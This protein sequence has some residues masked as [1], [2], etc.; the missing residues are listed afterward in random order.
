MT[1]GEPPG[2]RRAYRLPR[3]LVL[4]LTLIAFGLT[5]TALGAWLL[6]FLGWI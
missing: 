1:S 6:I 2:Q 4:V 3:L 5:L